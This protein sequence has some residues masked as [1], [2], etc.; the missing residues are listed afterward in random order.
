MTNLL[1]PVAVIL[2]LAGSAAA[3]DKQ[4]RQRAKTSTTSRKAGTIS[5]ADATRSNPS[6]ANTHDGTNGASTGGTGL[7]NEQ[8]QA[9][10]SGTARPTSVDPAS[11]VRTTAPATKA[12]KKAVKSGN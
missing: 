12:R 3:Q 8:Y 6:A 4:A 11:S 2:L 5:D 10:K 9:D 7:T 1:A